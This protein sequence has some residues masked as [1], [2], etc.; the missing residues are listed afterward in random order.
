MD[1]ASIKR[2]I[3]EN[4]TEINRLNARIGETLRDR[5]KGGKHYDEWSAA[6]AEFHARYDGLALPGGYERSRQK[7][8]EGDTGAIEAALCF[9][10]VR[11]YFFR[12]GYMFKDL[13]RKM[14]RATL[15]PQQRARMD[16]VVTK[17]AEFRASRA[18]K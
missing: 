16:V 12:S 18:K 6:C 10:E 9:L 14:K 17:Y 2:L 8:D 5:G 15:T 3:A 4:E 11:P 7:I 1:S 13:F